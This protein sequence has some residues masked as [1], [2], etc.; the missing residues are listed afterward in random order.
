LE[1]RDDEEEEE[2]DEDD[3][4]DDDEDLWLGL[5]RL[6]LRISAMNHWK[7]RKRPIA[8]AKKMSQWKRE[9]EV[10]KTTERRTTK[11]RPPKT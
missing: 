8:R 9:D 7:E 3:E 11:K 5:R 4:E 1:D 10:E 6:S 2:E